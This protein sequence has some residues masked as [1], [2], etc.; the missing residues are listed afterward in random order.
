M[1]FK[2]L[3]SV[4]FVQVHGKQKRGEYVKPWKGIGFPNITEF[5]RCFTDKRIE[6]LKAIKKHEPESVYALAKLLKRDYKNVYDDVKYL[7]DLG[8]IDRAE[9]HLS[10]GYDKIT[11]ECGLD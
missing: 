6:L 5:R 1:I 4:G 7:A 10:V 8:L 9:G 2:G 3:Y 11:M